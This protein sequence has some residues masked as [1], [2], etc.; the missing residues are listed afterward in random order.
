ME[1]T[2]LIGDFIIVNKLAYS[3]TTP[4][5]IPFTDVYI[6]PHKL[7]GI[8]KPEI[9][10]V[11][12][13][14]FPGN[15]NELHPPERLNYIKR[16]AAGPGDSM[17]IKDKDLIVNGLRIN[18][19][20]YLKIDRSAPRNRFNDQEMFYSYEN[21]DPAFYGPLT[22]P[23]KGYVLPLNRENIETWG[24]VI[25]REYGKNVVDIEGTVITIE[26]KPVKEY[27]FRKDYYFVL[28]D[29]RDDSMD[30]R[31]WGFVP[32]DYIIGKALMIYWSWT[33]ASSDF[34]I[35]KIFG[36]IRFE[37]IFTIIE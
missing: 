7:I 36:G 6:A 23:Y 30:S 37:R 8:S 10:D 14:E 20:A 35:M 5:N 33:S 4:R 32:E 3:I 22:V 1:N 27:T 25:N 31:Y 28:G 21:W 11:I 13:F 19:P 16:V 17:Q 9:N 12:V 24:M 26:G 29:N 15:K 18:E 2:L 34:D